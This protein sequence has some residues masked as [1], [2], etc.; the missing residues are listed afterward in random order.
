MAMDGRNLCMDCGKWFDVEDNET[1]T[2]FDHLCEKEKTAKKVFEG[3]LGGS[4]DDLSLHPTKEKADT[5]MKGNTTIDEDFE[6][7][8]N[9]KVRI[10][11]EVI[12]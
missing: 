3:W 6:E 9:K 10:T 4:F 8:K 11:V 5:G 7:F 1:E 2:F 12:E